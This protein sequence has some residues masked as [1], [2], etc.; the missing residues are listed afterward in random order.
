MERARADTEEYMMN[1]RAQIGALIDESGDILA[2]PQVDR[3]AFSCLEQFAS[4][5]GRKTQT[6]FQQMEWE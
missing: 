3:A 2:A 6:A 1:L 4:L 5:T